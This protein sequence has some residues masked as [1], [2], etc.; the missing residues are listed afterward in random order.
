MRYFVHPLSIQ[1]VVL[2]IQSS[3]HFCLHPVIS[4][5]LHLF[6]ALKNVWEAKIDDAVARAEKQWFRERATDLYG[7]ETEQD[8]KCTHSTTLLLPSLYLE[9][10]KVFGNPVMGIKCVYLF[11][12]TSVG[13]ILRS[14]K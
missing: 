6:L 11:S 10:R 1:V 5:G 13:N 9:K 8:M 14:D 7:P 2:V 3:F 12:V 4:F